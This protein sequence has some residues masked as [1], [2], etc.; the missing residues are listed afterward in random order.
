MEKAVSLQSPTIEYRLPD[1]LLKLEALEI[2]ENGRQ[3]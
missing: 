3:F 1:A 2:T